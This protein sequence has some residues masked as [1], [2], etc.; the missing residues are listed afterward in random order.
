MN[1]DS[2]GKVRGDE[3][4]KKETILPIKTRINYSICNKNFKVYLYGGIDEKS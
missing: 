4:E 1:D 3:N 2:T